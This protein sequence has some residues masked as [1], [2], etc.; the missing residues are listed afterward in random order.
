MSTQPE[1]HDDLDSTD[2]LPRLDVAAYE[3][4]LAEAARDG[5]SRTDTWAVEA[6][7]DL[8]DIAE[9]QQPD[10]PPPAQW[11]GPRN[12]GP[13]HLGTGEPPVNIARILQRM[14]QLESDIVAAHEANA[15][16]HKRNQSIHSARDEQMVRI[17]ALEADNARLAGHH[18]LADGMQERF[19]QQLREQS[20]HSDDQFKELQSARFAERLQM[21][22]EREDF[23][24][25]ATSMAAQVAALQQDNHKLQ[26]QLHASMTLANR[27][28]ASL[29]ALEASIGE[30][31]SSAG[32][33]ARQLASKLTDYETLSSMVELRNRSIGE[34]SRARD[35]LDQRLQRQTAAGI[36]LTA[37]LE[38]AS[39]AL[40]E[41]RAV[42]VVREDSIA[43]R[44]DRIAQLA[45][46]LARVSDELALERQQHAEAERS[47]SNLG[48]A[49]SES[50]NELSLRLQEI[51]ELRGALQLAESSVTETRKQLSTAAATAIEQER[52]HIER[53]SELQQIQQTNVVLTGERDAA[54][55]LIRNLTNERDALLPA[56]DQL[57]ERSSELGRSHSELTRVHADLAQARA[58]VASQIEAA[59]TRE[60]ESE[61][62]QQC[63]T[64]LRYSRDSLQEALEDAQQS[65]ER[66]RDEEQARIQLLDERTD[67]LAGLHTRFSEHDMAMRGM[68]QAIRMR[69]ELTEKLRGQLQSSQDEWSIMA[70]Q[71]EK[72]RARVKSM[73]QQIFQR[74]NQVAALRADL[75]ARSDAL[76]AI[77]RDVDRAE[78]DA[79]SDAF[80][81]FNLMLEPVAHDAE[82]IF[83]NNKLITIGRT[84]ENDVCI[85]SKLV[86]RHHARLLV[87]AS[88]VVI[89]DAGSTNGCFVNGQQVQQHQLHEGD[90]LEFGDL[91]YR[92]CTRAPSDTR[93][94]ANVVPIRE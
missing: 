43:T 19:E 42:L 32:Q 29:A 31:K 69:D 33:L 2:E 57:V 73:A 44:D 90:V 52:L 13:H 58:E 75:S 71:L 88:G 16:L 41:S 22:Q 54:L 59:Q 5:L 77:R 36:E 8:D 6:L 12:P 92:L 83:L 3:A 55:E 80:A 37:Q 86:S 62:L 85:P 91:R 67:E 68:E 47:V 78:A 89:E 72:S 76:A 14:A 7:Q 46:D 4:S 82:P 87:G 34:L 56:A 70:G 10:P 40:Q 61:S 66:M 26:D 28:A 45:S 17:R 84:S 1:S 15:A 65:L 64:Q 60:T 9:A 63:V 11:P 50:H 51:H 21:D 20:Q 74:D 94:R 79:D 35:D 23:R 39:K 30:E 24:R 93:M 38:V 18:A 27:H 81:Q 53:G 48:A 25:Q 49:Q